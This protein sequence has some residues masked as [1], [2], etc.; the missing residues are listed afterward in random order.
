MT[1]NGDVMGRHKLDVRQDSNM[2]CHF[3]PLVLAD[4]VDPG[5]LRWKLTVMSPVKNSLS[6]SLFRPALQ[7]KTN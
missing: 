3:H 4:P 7:T 1:E 2:A 5:H 6:G